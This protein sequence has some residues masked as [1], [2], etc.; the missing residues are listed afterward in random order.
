LDSLTIKWW[1]H[2]LLQ[3]PSVYYVSI[4]AYDTV[5]IP[6]EDFNFISNTYYSMKFE[7]SAPNG[8]LDNFP[9]NNEFSQNYHHL[10]PVSIK[11]TV[12]VQCNSGTELYIPKFY[13]DSIQWSTGQTSNSIFIPGPGTYSVTITD[14]NGC[15]VSDTII[16]N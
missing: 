3:D 10:G 11:K 13:Y 2:G 7:I 1:L 16:I 5:D 6:I 9:N 8:N 4:P 12:D 15:N 14:F